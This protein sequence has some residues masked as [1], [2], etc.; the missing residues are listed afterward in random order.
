M[1][2]KHRISLFFPL[3]LALWTSITTRMKTTA[4]FFSAACPADR[5]RA[6]EA[7]NLH[8]NAVHADAAP[9]RDRASVGLF[10]RKVAKGGN[11]GGPP[12]GMVMPDMSIGGMPCYA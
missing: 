11:D 2:E 3:A 9:K 10:R 1:Q 12:A 4:A 8:S 5:A 6:I 7:F